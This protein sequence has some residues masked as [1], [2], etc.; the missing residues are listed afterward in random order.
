MPLDYSALFGLEGKVAIV[1]GAAQG[2]GEG[3]A[4]I[5][6]DAGAAVALTDIQAEAVGAAAT[7][8]NEAGGRAS[9]FA[10]DMTDEAAIIAGIDAARAEFGRLDILVN[11]AG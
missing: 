2:M 8:I 4:R 10:M 3:I 5:L 6:A 7:R 11:C 1:T 9:A